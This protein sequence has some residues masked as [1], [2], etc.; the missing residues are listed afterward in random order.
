MLTKELP[1]QNVVSSC[2]EKGLHRN[3][4]VKIT[5]SRIA[6][7]K[8]GGQSCTMIQIPKIFGFNPFIQPLAPVYEEVLYF[9]SLSSVRARRLPT[10]PSAEFLKGLLLL[11]VLLL[12]VL[13]LLLVLLLKAR[14]LLLH[15]LVPCM[16]HSSEFHSLALEDFEGPLVARSRPQAPAG[17]EGSSSPAPAH[18]GGTKFPPPRSFPLP[19]LSQLQQSL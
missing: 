3:L 2:Y 15:L 18:G 12:K 11:Q 13:L 19:P 9:L 5:S 8:P 6:T 14:G 16:C 7:L 1:S 4:T 10:T 17:S